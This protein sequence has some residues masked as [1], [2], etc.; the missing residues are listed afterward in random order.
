M[1]LAHPSA[2]PNS[3]WRFPSPPGP[4]WNKTCIDC[5]RPC[6]RP[7]RGQAGYIRNGSKYRNRCTVG[8]SGVRTCILD[9]ARS[10]RTSAAAT[11]HIAR[12]A[13]PYVYPASEERAVQRFPSSPA[14]LQIAFPASRRCPD[15]RVGDISGR[16]RTPPC[17]NRILSRLAG[18]STSVRRTETHACSA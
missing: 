10:V 8:R 3:A 14:S 16:T 17:S 11:F 12:N 7:A 9:I 13:T 6:A 1:L 18:I 15:N 2:S 5:V 4:A